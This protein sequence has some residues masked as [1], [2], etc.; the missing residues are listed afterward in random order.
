MISIEYLLLWIPFFQNT[1]LWGDAD[2]ECSN[3]IIQHPCV[4]EKR[5]VSHMDPLKMKAVCSFKIF[6]FYYSMTQFYI[7]KEWNPELCC[8]E[9]TL[10]FVSTSFV[11]NSM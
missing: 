9:N 10:Y 6:V 1:S 5:A 11:A 3:E 8:Y 2:S 7:P 4:L